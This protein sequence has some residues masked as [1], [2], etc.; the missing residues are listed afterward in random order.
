MEVDYDLILCVYNSLVRNIL[1]SV[2]IRKVK[3][4][5]E[6][7]VNGEVECDD[8]VHSMAIYILKHP[9]MKM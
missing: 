9:M 5:C 4:M 3:I 6:G 1:P 8:I 2:N 7:I